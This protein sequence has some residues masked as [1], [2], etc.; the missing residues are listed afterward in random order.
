MKI[1]LAIAWRVLVVILIFSPF[2]YAVKTGWNPHFE[3]GILV[4][5][6]IVKYPSITLFTF[7]ISGN[8]GRAIST[9]SEMSG[10]QSGIIID[11]VKF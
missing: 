6:R 1:F 9:Y 5:D 7:D 10:W 4:D 8:K 11:V 3:K 2:Y